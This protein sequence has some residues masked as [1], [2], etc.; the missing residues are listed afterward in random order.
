MY[1]CFNY[2]KDIRHSCE[3]TANMGSTS[4]TIIVGV[5]QQ[6]SRTQLV[7]RD[8]DHSPTLTHTI[9]PTIGV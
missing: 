7:H 6:D 2:D 4:I 3:N 5:A 1:G 8:A 9:C